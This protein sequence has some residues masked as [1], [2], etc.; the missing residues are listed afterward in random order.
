M[1]QEIKNEPDSSLNFSIS[2]GKTISSIFNFLDANL[3]NFVSDLTSG[4]NNEDDVSQECSI[5]LNRLAGNNLFM[6]H[7]QHK[8]PG[9]SRSSDLSVISAQKFTSKD[10]LVVIE[11]KRLPTPGKN[12][13]REYVQ[14]NRGAMERFKRGHHGK[15]LPQAVILGY[16]QKNN[17]EYWHKE[18]CNWIDDLINGNNDSSIHWSKDDLLVMNSNMGGMNK[19][20]SNNSRIGS[21]NIIITHYW[22]SLSS[23]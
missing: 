7:F 19:Y 15:G 4:L 13:V 5:F 11:A 1:L 16:I 17:F 12:R 2:K 9:R 21:T 22:L 20:I 3:P 10:P 6:F 8:Y 18:V 14:G 23:Q